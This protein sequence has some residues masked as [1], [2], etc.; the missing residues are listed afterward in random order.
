MCL[1][2]GKANIQEAVTLLSCLEQL[3]EMLDDNIEGRGLGTVCGFSL[4]RLIHSAA[5]MESTD[6]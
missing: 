5:D 1:R 4:E 2:Q 6:N 3:V